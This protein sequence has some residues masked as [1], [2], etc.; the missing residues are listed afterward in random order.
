MKI[1]IVSVGD[2]RHISMI[3][4]YTEYFDKNN[5]DYDILCTDRYE[6]T[7]YPSSNIKAYP[8]KNVKRKN[9]KL[10]MFLSFYKW[11]SRIIKNEKYDFLVIWNENT[12]PLFAPLLLTKY[13]HR[14]C[15]NIRDVDFLNQKA[16]NVVRARVIRN[17]AF[18]TYCSTAKL[19]FPKG[20]PYV[21]MR[22]INMKILQE[23]TPRTEFRKPGEKIRI[24]NIGKIRFPMANKRIIEALGNDERFELLFIGA[25]SEKLESY[26]E[27]YNNITLIGAYLPEDTAKYL[28]EA[29]IINSY[30]GS[31][32]LGFERMTSIRFSY[33]PYLHI[34]VLVGEGTE[35]EHEGNKYGFIYAV[36]EGDTSFSDDLYRWYCN[37]DYN[38]FAHGCRRY[39]ADIDETDRHFYELLDK[40]FAKKSRE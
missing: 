12:A 32:V 13:R 2:Y 17:S 20:Y 23:T 31:T 9:E 22:S 29:D 30:F 1:A 19:D 5:I 4:K 38:T 39:L 28:A 16:V 21:L 14:Y 3:S 10:R 7:V 8:C 35:M 36:G 24:V 25:G 27:K 33:G 37:L 11:A 34:P 40:L 15:V 26:K 18:S 6:G